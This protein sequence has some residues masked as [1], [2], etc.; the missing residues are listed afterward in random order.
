MQCSIPDPIGVMPGSLQ[1]LHLL[2]SPTTEQNPS[3]SD[4]RQEAS[5]GNEIWPRVKQTRASCGF[6]VLAESIVMRRTTPWGKNSNEVFV[7]G[8]CTWQARSLERGASTL[9]RVEALEYKSSLCLLQCLFSPSRTLGVTADRH[10]PK[11]T[12]TIYPRTLIFG[13]LVPTR[14]HGCHVKEAR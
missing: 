8:S 11:D 14:H 3:G 13:P 5:P 12:P 7:G 9:S 10:R 6:E 1:S 4:P 2:V